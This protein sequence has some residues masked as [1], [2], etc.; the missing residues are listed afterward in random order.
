[1][2]ASPHSAGSSRHDGHK[3]MVFGLLGSLL[4]CIVSDDFSVSSNCFSPCKQRKW[5]VT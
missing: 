1:M 3:W 2:F 5:E 4:V